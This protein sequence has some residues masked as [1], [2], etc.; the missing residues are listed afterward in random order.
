MQA[1]SAGAFEHRAQPLLLEPLP[2][3]LGGQFERFEGNV[4]R[5]IEVEYQTVWIVDRVDGGTPG[6]YLDRTHL[7]D[8]QQPFLVFNVGIL[9]TLPF[10]PEIERMNIR[11]NAPA[12]ITLIE[13]LAVDAGRTAQQAERTPRNSRQ[14]EGSYRSVVLG[15]FTLGDMAAGRNDTLWMRDRDARRHENAKC[16]SA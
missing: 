7:N 4:W 3:I 11:P 2:Q 15:Q 14:H 13:T 12:R 6:V 9:V 16:H 10:V 5:R 1:L 8:L